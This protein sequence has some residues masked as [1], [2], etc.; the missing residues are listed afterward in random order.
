MLSMGHGPCNA[1]A[2]AYIILFFSLALFGKWCQRVTLLVYEAWA[3]QRYVLP[4]TKSQHNLNSS[5][6][7]IHR[8]ILNRRSGMNCDDNIHLASV[9]SSP[10]GQIF[11]NAF[12][13]AGHTGHSVH[14]HAHYFELLGSMHQFQFFP[15][16]PSGSV[17]RCF[18]SGIQNGH[19]MDGV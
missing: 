18:L 12:L 15:W 13:Q 4:Y 3:C 16:W 8:I 19:F 11:H 9:P 10:C 2:I 7:Y 5:V 17:P 1:T 6:I 14:M